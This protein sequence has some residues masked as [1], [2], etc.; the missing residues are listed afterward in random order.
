MF[1]E[2][3]LL[4]SSWN[5][6]V[7]ILE[8]KY[9]SLKS[10]FD[11]YI[12]GFS[13]PNGDDYAM[14]SSVAKH[15]RVLNR[16][17]AGLDIPSDY[18]QMMETYLDVS[19]CLEVQKIR[20]FDDKEMEECQKILAIDRLIPL[21]PRQKD[22]SYIGCTLENLCHS[23]SLKDYRNYKKYYCNLLGL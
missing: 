14:L 10:D 9:P 13:F 2:E 15:P 7:E 11:E 21:S 18:Q 8:D 20:Q 23:H 16:F 19:L 6:M 1:K 22:L 4:R 5:K 12:M 3:E 17:I